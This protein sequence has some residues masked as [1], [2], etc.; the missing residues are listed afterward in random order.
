MGTKSKN[1]PP[2]HEKTLSVINRPI[3]FIV[4]NN[5]PVTLIPKTKFNNK[6]VIKPVTEDYRDVNDNKIMLESRTTEN[7]D[8]DGTKQQLEFLITTSRQT[9][10][11]LGLDWMKT[12]HHPTT[13]KTA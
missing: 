2:F 4:D 7:I 5:S 10:L 1:G 3:K 13:D 9:H 11:L 12:G 6:T 8:G